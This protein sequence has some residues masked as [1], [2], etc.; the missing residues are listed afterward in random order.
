MIDAR[1]SVEAFQLAG[2]I[3]EL[4]ADDREYQQLRKDMTVVVSFPVKPDGTTIAYRDA[5][6]PHGQ[7]P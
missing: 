7:T 2:D 3:Q 4:L 5:L 6:N 1:R